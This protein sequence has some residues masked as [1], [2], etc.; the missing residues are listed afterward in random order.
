MADK[1]RAKPL[2]GG[3]IVKKKK[4]VVIYNFACKRAKQRLR[5][6]AVK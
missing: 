3:Q 2:L 6:F 5:L 4:K 1:G